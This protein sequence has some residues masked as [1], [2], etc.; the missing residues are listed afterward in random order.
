VIQQMAQHNGGERR[1][2]GTTFPG[3]RDAVS[4]VFSFP[5]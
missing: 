3:N 2:T 5:G 4:Q 1:F